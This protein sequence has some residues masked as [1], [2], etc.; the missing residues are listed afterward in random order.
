MH[1]GNNTKATLKQFFYILFLCLVIYLY[2]SHISP[3]SETL[4]GDEASTKYIEAITPAPEPV[5]PPPRWKRSKSEWERDKI[6]LAEL[7]YGK[8]ALRNKEVPPYFDTSNGKELFKTH[9]K[10][11]DCLSTF[12]TETLQLRLVKG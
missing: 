7:E 5:P 9:A 4:E 8:Q 10:K 12:L 3:L 11:G 1:Q 2:K 6:E